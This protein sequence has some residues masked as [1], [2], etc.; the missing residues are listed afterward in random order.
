MLSQIFQFPFLDFSPFKT[1]N[2]NTIITRYERSIVDG[3]TTDG[4]AL[5]QMNSPKLAQIYGKYC[6]L[7]QCKKEEVISSMGQCTDIVPD[8]YEK[9]SRKKTDERTTWKKKVSGYQLTKI[10]RFSIKL[11]KQ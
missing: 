4:S 5:V 8:V 3:C 10:H 6:K 7:D 11:M 9:G 2:N 1:G